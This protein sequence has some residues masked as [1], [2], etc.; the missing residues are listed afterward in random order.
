MTDLNRVTFRITYVEKL[1]VAAILN[2]SGR[3]TAT[4]ELIMTFL[5]LL[6]KHNR[7]KRIGHGKAGLFHLRFG[8]QQNPWPIIPREL[9]SY[10]GRQSIVPVLRAHDNLAVECLNPPL[11]RGIHLQVG[12]RNRI[13]VEQRQCCL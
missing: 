7:R 3:E 6:A 12:E 13:C 11:F 9:Q 5:Q 10:I 2:W 4:C 1:G 8:Q